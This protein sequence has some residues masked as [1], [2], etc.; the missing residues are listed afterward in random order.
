MLSFLVAFCNKAADIHAAGNYLILTFFC[1][2]YRKR[3]AKKV[4]ALW[5]TLLC[6][7][8]I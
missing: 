1:V 3:F 6:G 7:V 8:H 5:I 2:C 4:K